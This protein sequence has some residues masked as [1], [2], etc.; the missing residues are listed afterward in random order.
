MTAS[1]HPLVFRPLVEI[2]EARGD[3]VEITARDYAQTIQLI[4][5]HG[6]K[7]TVIGH[8]GGRSRAGKAR[9]LV[10]RLGALKRWARARE[11][12]VALAHGS[13]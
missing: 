8:H 9:Q 1:A 12:D 3:T 13:S 6:M 2:M 10:S 5:Q 11:F 7:A 4:E